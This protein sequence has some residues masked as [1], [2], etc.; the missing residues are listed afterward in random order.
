MSNAGIPWA[1]VIQILILG[2]FLI[3]VTIRP[4]GIWQI[5]KMLEQDDESRGKIASIVDIAQ[6]R[7]INTINSLIKKFV[8][9]TD[10]INEIYLKDKISN[11]IDYAI[12]RHD[13][14]EDQR[15]RIF[16][17]IIAVS[18][19]IL[20]VVG[21]SIDSQFIT[22]N[23]LH[24][25]LFGLIFIAL[26]SIILSSYIYNAE[27]DGDRSY[28]LV[29]DIRFWF[30]RYNL[31]EHSDKADSQSALVERAKEVLSQRERFFDRASEN[32]NLDKSIRED[33]EQIFILHTLQRY[34]SESLSQLRWLLPYLVIF[35]A[36]EVGF[37]LI[38]AVA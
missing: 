30:F 8:N 7:E 38:L 12:K 17:F 33:L 20:T 9:T 28:R 1:W 13:W 31:P 26:T 21:L 6:K 34:K 19:V 10:E 18:T 24:V 16:Q 37:L 11:S 14:Y 5:G 4:K 35:F 27:L 2:I 3:V 32:F 22:Q 15:F 25:I 23:R 29:S 36:I